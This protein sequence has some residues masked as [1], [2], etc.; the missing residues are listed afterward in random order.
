MSNNDYAIG[1]WWTG[2]RRIEGDELRAIER[3]AA[4]TLDILTDEPIGRQPV[5][6][7]VLTTCGDCGKGYEKDPVVGG[8]K[9]LCPSCRS[10]RAHQARQAQGRA[11][12]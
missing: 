3:R 7:R 5:T 1:E 10:R 2:Y 9:A 6:M 12:A 11:G 4:A 8:A